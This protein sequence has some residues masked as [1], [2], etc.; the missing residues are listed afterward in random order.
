MSKK[1]I[2][3]EANKIRSELRYGKLD[4]MQKRFMKNFLSRN[5]GVFWSMILLVIG[6]TVISLVLPFIS[7]FYLE[8]SFALMNYGTFVIVG[9][10]LIVLIILFLAA[11]YLQ[12]FVT[13]IF[14][15]RFI[16]EIRESWYGYFLK[17]SVAFN[18]NFDGKKLLTKMLYHLQLLRMGMDNVV[19]QFIQGTFLYIGII[20]FSFLFNPRLFVVLW[21]SLP[22]LIIVFLIMDYIGRYYVTREQ[23]F[24]SRIV[25]HLAD[26]LINF[27]VIKVQARED[28]MIKKFADYIEL[29]TFF[30]IRRQLWVQY[31]NRLLYGLI[32]LFGVVLYF[33]QLY[34]PF[35]EFDSISNVASTG[36]LLG[37]FSKV[38]FSYSRAGIFT[39]AFR[40]GLRLSIPTFSYVA[41]KSSPKPVKFNHIKFSGKRVKISK[42]GGYIKD[43]I[44]SFKKGQRI[45]VY[46]DENAGK[47]TFAKVITGQKAIKSINVT[48]D[49]KRVTSARWC[50]YKSGNY[51]V[52]AN[53]TF[54]I[55]IGE[56][57]SGK[58]TESI[59]QKDIDHIFKLLKPYKVFDFIFADTDMLGRRISPRNIS[60]TEIVLVQIAHCLVHPKSIVAIDHGCVDI[61]RDI[62]ENAIKILEKNCDLTAIIV[63]SSDKNTLIKYEKTFHLNKAGLSEV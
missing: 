62:I 49:K 44:F 30:R 22:V 35:I 21:V 53:P 20:I 16:N 28:G 24:N 52:S 42:Y 1:Q 29:D 50:G 46:G 36:L 7:H 37:F 31:S 17:R 63:F 40:L 4:G 55:S 2:I 47:T 45:L 18:K 32:L 27:D 3:S 26:S 51:F 33:V 61:K 8:K 23:T 59:T 34:W 13:Q 43:F 6:E 60:M 10:T 39:E 9:I 48:L 58:N 12:I 54:D 19:Y 5:K 15:L 57:L 14:S 25:S 41:E 38:V 11:S 56:Y